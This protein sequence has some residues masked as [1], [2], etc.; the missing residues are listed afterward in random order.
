MADE[1]A[2]KPD[3]SRRFEQLS[4]IKF[5]DPSYGLFYMNFQKFKRNSEISL[6]I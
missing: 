3:S 1:R 5:L 2:A 6:I 4:Y